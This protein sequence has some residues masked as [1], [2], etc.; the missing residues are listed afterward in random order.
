MRPLHVL[1]A[2]PLAITVLFAAP[3][4][5]MAADPPKTDAPKSDPSS[6]GAETKSG[7]EVAKEETDRTVYLAISPLHL[8]LPVVH[9]TGEARLGR[10]FGAALI[11]GYGGIS[12]D[13]GLG[14]RMKF[15]VWEVGGQFV[16]YPVGHFDHGMQLGAQAL[17]VGLSGDQNIGSVKITG[18][19]TGLGVGP[20]VGYKLAT[21]VGFSFNVQGGV[22]YMAVRATASTTG[23]SASASGSQFGPILNI[24]VGWSI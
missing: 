1:A 8:I 19:G 23:D 21:K 15:T 2:L 22:Q 9:L 12:V 4:A 17:Y 5:A 13:D 24:N 16:S 18:A 3:R 7:D 11:G 20:F 14:G 10:Q 6:A